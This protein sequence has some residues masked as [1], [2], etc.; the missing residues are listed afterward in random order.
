MC[1]I[2]FVGP[3]VRIFQFY[4]LHSRFHKNIN[5]FTL[6]SFVLMRYQSTRFT[7]YHLFVLFINFK[8]MNFKNN[9]SY[10]SSWLRKGPSANG[11]FFG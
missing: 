5:K 6:L 10:G 1:V 8:P 7:L 3:K 9:T 11:R 4:F 2:T